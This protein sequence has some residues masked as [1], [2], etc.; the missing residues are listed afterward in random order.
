MWKYF[1][2]FKEESTNNNKNPCVNCTFTMKIFQNYKYSL[3]N[4]STLTSWTPIIS[5]SRNLKRWK[6]AYIVQEM[7]TLNE[8]VEVLESTACTAA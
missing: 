3:V 6:A 1:K 4:E 2:K 8:T 5:S 7:Q